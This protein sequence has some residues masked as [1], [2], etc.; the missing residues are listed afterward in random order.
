MKK[1]VGTYQFQYAE[2]RIGNT[3]MTGSAMVQFTSNTLVGKSPG[4]SNPRDYS[5]EVFPTLAGRYLTLQCTINKQF[6]IDEIW[7]FQEL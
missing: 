3:D 1:A 6:A 4:G 5:Y 7:V 2:L